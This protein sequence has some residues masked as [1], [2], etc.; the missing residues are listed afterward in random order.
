MNK[1]TTKKVNGVDNGLSPDMQTVRE[2]IL[3][4]E[5][6]ARHWKAQYETAYYHLEF[7]KILPAYR[8]LIDRQRKENEEANK[9]HQEYIEN[10]KKQIP[11]IDV[12]PV[13]TGQS[14][15]ENI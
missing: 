10:L 4:D 5:L 9:K 15:L 1:K 2:Q 8:E 12:T 11:E 14:A 3:I 13:D 7:E 6:K